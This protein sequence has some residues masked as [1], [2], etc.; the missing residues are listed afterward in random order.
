VIVSGSVSL[1]FH[2][3]L[4]KKYENY[5][6]TVGDLQDAASPLAQAQTGYMIDT[7]IHL[8]F[9]QAYFAIHYTHI[10]NQIPCPAKHR[11]QLG[12]MVLTN[13]MICMGSLPQQTSV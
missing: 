6:Q 3:C 9:H 11:Y 10:S 4:F 5:M 2:L 1:R 13:T 12:I 7:V 8:T